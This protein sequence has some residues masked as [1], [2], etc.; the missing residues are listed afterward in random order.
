MSK[1]K[2]KIGVDGVRDDG[3]SHYA[4]S[5][6]DLEEFDE[7]R[8]ALAAMRTP[9][10]V[11]KPNDRLFVAAFDGTGNDRNSDPEHTTNVA[12]IASQ[13]ESRNAR[14]DDSVAVGYVEGIG[15]Q[16]NA[17]TRLTDGAIGYTFDERLEQMYKKLIDQ[18]SVWRSEDPNVQINIADIGFSRGAEQ[19]AAFARMVHER[20]IQDPSGRIE[21]KDDHGRTVVEYTKPPLVPPGQV[22]QAVG[23]FDP[24]GTGE[25]RN[26][27]RRLPPSVISGFQLTAQ[28]ER[29]GQFKGTDLIDQGM[30]PDGRFF[31]VML[32]GCHSDIGG[33]YHR[34]GL[35]IRAGN[36]MTDYLNS[37][38]DTPF[39][40]KRAEPTAPGM[41]V[42]HRSEEGM[43]L[44]RMWDKVDRMKDGR[45]DVLTPA[46]MC[47]RVADCRNAEARDEA[48]A[49]RFD[50]AP[51]RVGPTPVDR[52]ST[53]P[54]PTNDATSPDHPANRLLLQSM[55]ATDRLDT[56]LGVER[57]PFSERLAVDSAVQAQKAGLS[58][59]DHIVINEQGTHALV[60][61]GRM[62]APPRRTAQVEL[63][64]LPEHGIAAGLQRLDE[65]T[66]QRV[67][68]DATRAPAVQT[69]E[70]ATPAMAR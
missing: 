5:K 41:N 15:T 6:Q 17:V 2:H 54:L 50:F 52:H 22:A 26:H 68:R 58:R 48:L 39:L 62:D 33:S 45:V 4:A 7:T 29:R 14:G 59:I 30:T 11:A 23:L 53:A 8:T 61:E 31:G 25:P 12:E 57:S 28:D 56:R 69:T 42:I 37:L 64:A 16:S 70:P 43:L 46:T 21:R 47:G 66:D 32:P 19:A 13:I 18:A 65:A 60:V 67:Q 38:S 44:Y 1:D 51:V 34:N 10:L 27:D 40:E 55:A 24:V 20:G 3:V 35:S 36:L 9:R 63:S 49:S